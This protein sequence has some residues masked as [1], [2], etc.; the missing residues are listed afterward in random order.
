MPSPKKCPECSSKAVRLY[1]NKTV[2]GKRKWIPVAWICTKC[3][4]VYTVASDILIYPVG[5]EPYLENYDHHCPKCDLKLR[6][7]F[8]HENPVHGKQQ[9]LTMGWYC[10]LCKQV[11]LDQKQEKNIPV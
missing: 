10:S 6:R 7:V 8:R 2:D 1:I 5:G 4:F 3:S 9:F 11:W